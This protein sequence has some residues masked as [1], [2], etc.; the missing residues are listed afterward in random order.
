MQAVLSGLPG[1]VLLRGVL[2]SRETREGRLETIRKLLAMAKDQAN[3]HLAAAA[4][5]KATKLMLEAQIDEA[6]LGDVESEPVADVDLLEAAGIE[7]GPVSWH[8]LMAQGLAKANGC[9]VFEEKVSD[10][11]GGTAKRM[12]VFGAPSDIAAVRYLFTY[13]AAEVDRLAGEHEARLLE[14]QRMDD[15]T[16]NL[17]RNRWT[18]RVDEGGVDAERAEAQRR[19]RQRSD[20]SFRLGAAQGIAVKAV[21]SRQ[22]VRDRALALNQERGLAHL[23]QKEKLLE[24]F[25]TQIAAGG[26]PKTAEENVAVDNMQ[27]YRL[28]Y[29]AGKSVALKAEGPGLAPP[30]EEQRAL[31]APREALP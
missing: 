3:V 10:G 6:E 31:P 5:A 13:C 26:A 14:K 23:D 21:T 19:E 12:Q 28:G 27:S 2:V 9:K 24:D 15:R 25:I 29:R 17:L 30:P 16:L 8:Y 22:E 20:S 4:A 1:R 11:A 18:S 7:G